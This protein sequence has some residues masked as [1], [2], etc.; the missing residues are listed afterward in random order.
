[1]RMWSPPPERPISLCWLPL[2]LLGWS[3]LLT[4]FL[5][6][7]CLSYPFAKWGCWKW[8]LLQPL[9]QDRKNKVNFYP[10]GLQLKRQLAAWML[11]P[12]GCSKTELALWE[13][14][15][16]PPVAGGTGVSLPQ[17]KLSAAETEMF[18]RGKGSTRALKRGALKAADPCAEMRSTAFF[19][20]EGHFQW[21]NIKKRKESDWSLFNI[22]WHQNAFIPHT[23]TSF[24]RGVHSICPGSAGSTTSVSLQEVPCHHSGTPTNPAAHWPVGRR[25]AQVGRGHVRSMNLFF[26]ASTLISFQ[27][28]ASFL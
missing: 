23:F 25:K 4:Y 3:E 27:V 12:F 18:P 5:F 11:S 7:A 21:I 16:S 20:R 15:V 26:T 24:L 13:A 1:M 14:A 19:T 9:S 6:S 28:W 22:F 17:V 8:L 10:D 2:L